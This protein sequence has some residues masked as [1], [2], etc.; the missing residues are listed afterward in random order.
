MNDEVPL[1]DNFPL[2]ELTQEVEAP[3]LTPYESLSERDRLFYDLFVEMNRR[4]LK[5]TQQLEDLIRLSS[6]RISPS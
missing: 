1:M 4:T 5:M 6:V 2:E 3:V